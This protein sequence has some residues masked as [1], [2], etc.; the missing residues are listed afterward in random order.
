[1]IRALETAEATRPAGTVTI[2][3][4][5]MSTKKVNILPPAVM[6]T[7]SPYP[8]VVRVTIAHQKLHQ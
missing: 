6:G 3:T 5:T 1:M 7:T 4:P 8:T 2:P